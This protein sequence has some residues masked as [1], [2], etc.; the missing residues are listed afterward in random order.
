MYRHHHRLLVLKHSLARDSQKKSE[1]GFS[2]CLFVRHGTYS[3]SYQYWF[4]VLLLLHHLLRPGQAPMATSMKIV[5]VQ[6]NEGGSTSSTHETIGPIITWLFFQVR[7]ITKNEEQD[8]MP[9]SSSFDTG[10]ISSTI[11]RFR[12]IYLRTH[13]KFWNSFAARNFILG[14]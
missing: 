5:F 10:S 8:M 9:T 11:S 12:T 7:L 6:E 14:H 3:T 2:G 4:Q 13:P 1:C